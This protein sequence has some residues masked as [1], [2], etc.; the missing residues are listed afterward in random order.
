MVRHS[1]THQKKE[2][3]WILCVFYFREKKLDE[4]RSRR[5]AKEEQCSRMEEMLDKGEDK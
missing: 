1:F 2:D 4:E 3:F 5:E